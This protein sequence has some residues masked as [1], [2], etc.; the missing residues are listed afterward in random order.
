M[1]EFNEKLDWL[2]SQAKRHLQ[3]LFNLRYTAD[4]LRDYGR[5]PVDQVE[6]TAATAIPITH[7]TVSSATFLEVLTENH[8]KKFN[9]APGSFD[10]CPF[11]AILRNG[12]T[13]SCVLDSRHDV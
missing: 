10:L 5:T 6:V 13:T 1:S 2:S 9:H 7:D 3:N 8:I 11:C 12:K 4:V